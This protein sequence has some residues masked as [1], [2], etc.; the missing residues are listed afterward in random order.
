MK[1]TYNEIFLRNQILANIPTQRDGR[2]LSAG[3]ATSLLLLRIAYQNKMEEYDGICRKALD[4]IKKDG[5]YA[6]FDEKAQA[7]EEAKRV[8]AMKKAYDEWKE[9]D[10]ERPACPSQEE[11]EKA[12][13]AKAESAEF[14]RMM[15]ELTEAYGAARA[16]QAA[17]ETGIEV[18]KLTRAE[19]EDIVGVVGTDG[20]VRMKTPNG[21]FDEPCMSFLAMVAKYFA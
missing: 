1:F 3:T 15:T 10:G 5:K 12:E 19:L 14:E 20:D 4:D 18:N 7:Q 21:E 11:I 13:G 8:L 17:V 6:G 2:K 16:K 9:T